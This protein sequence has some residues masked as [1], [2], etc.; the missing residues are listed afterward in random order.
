MS[1][2][3]PTARPT[4]GSGPGVGAFFDLDNTLIRGAAIEIR[5]F[6]Y[7]WKQGVVGRREALRSLRF[8]LTQVPPMSLHPLRERKVYLSGKKPAV[9]EALAERFIRTE[10]R[11]HLSR[12]GLAALAAHQRAAHCVAIVTGA[13]DFL[14]APLAASLQVEAALAAKPERNGEVYTGT[15]MAPPPYGEVK[16]QLLESF[17]KERGVD[18]RA[19]Y[20]YGDSPGDTAVLRLVGFPLVVNPIR[21]MA[22]IA[23]REG[24]PIAKWK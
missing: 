7:L 24:W 22:R 6:R 19:S 13:P 23:R 1:Q 17:A 8:L 11:P 4:P 20:A 21:G 9:I 15:L 5:F 14:V 16:R 3:A 10:I 2:F 18:L 12:D